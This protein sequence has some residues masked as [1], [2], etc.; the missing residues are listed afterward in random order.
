MT[1]DFNIRDNL[2]N[3]N[4]PHH[5][6]HNNLLINIVE[7]IHLGFY[8]LSNHIP[9]RYSN[10]NHDLNSVI[11][12]M[13]LRYGSEELNKH[14]IYPEWSVYNHAPLMVTIPIFKKYI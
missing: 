10:N 13:F 1:G 11:N 12:L 5:S 3:P 7:S 4:Y 2:W 9:T 8:F 14:S 6:I